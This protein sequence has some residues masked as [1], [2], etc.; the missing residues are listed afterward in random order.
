MLRVVRGDDRRAWGFLCGRCR[1][2]INPHCVWK[3]FEARRTLHEAL[4]M[5]VV[6][7]QA[8]VMT[9]LEHRGGAPVV[10]VGWGEIGQPAV[11]MRLV[12]PR[13]EIVADVAGVFDRAE[14]IRKLRSVFERPELE[15]GRASCRERVLASV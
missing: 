14:S 1:R 2:R 9:D 8:R 7:G 3:D 10:D 6:R 15:I 4:G 11:M 5:R 13:E 12:V